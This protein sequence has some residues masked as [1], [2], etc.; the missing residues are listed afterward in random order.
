MV[1]LYK[2]IVFGIVFNTPGSR[3]DCNSI[4]PSLMIGLSEYVCDL[5]NI[6]SDLLYFV[7]NGSTWPNVY[8]YEV[9]S[10]DPWRKI[11]LKP[12]RDQ[13]TRE[14]LPEPKQTSIFPQKWFLLSTSTNQ[15]STIPH[16]IHPLTYLYALI[17][18]FSTHLSNPRFIVYDI[19]SICNQIDYNMEWY[20]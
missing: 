19:D 6:I 8:Q 4:R 2:L 10:F 12:W 14:N 18:I 16:S 11:N 5:C 13:P 15:I 17:H 9:S 3:L 20:A 7:E 1:K